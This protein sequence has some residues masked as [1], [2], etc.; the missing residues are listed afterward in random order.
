[1]QFLKNVKRLGQSCSFVVVFGCH[2]LPMH[3]VDRVGFFLVVYVKRFNLTTEIPL[4]PTLSVISPTFSY[5][6]HSQFSAALSQLSA[7]LSQLSAP[8]SQL[9]ASL[10]QL[11]AP[12]SQLSASLSIICPTLS[13]ISLTPSYLPHSLSQFNIM[14]M[15]K[16]SLA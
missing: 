9:S 11:S 2:I 14:S 15:V 5:Q 3:R 16:V 7:P 13:V 8:L 10:S 1:M 4:C 6:P 12:L